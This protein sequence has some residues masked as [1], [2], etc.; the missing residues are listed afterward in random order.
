MCATCRLGHQVV[1]GQGLLVLWKLGQQ[2][3]ARMPGA[4]VA[5]VGMDAVPRILLLM[6]WGQVCSCSNPSP[7]AP[8]ME[9]PVV[10]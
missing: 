9:V 7:V 6:L 1:Q 4:V 5:E 2:L 10:L 8:A 3:A